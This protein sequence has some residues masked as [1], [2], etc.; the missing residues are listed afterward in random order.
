MKKRKKI[1]YSS[2]IDLYIGYMFQKSSIIILLV[3]VFVMGVCAYFI[4]NP[5]MEEVEYLASYKDYHQC[6]FSQLLLIVQIFNCIICT[7][8]VI[9]LSLNSHSFDILFTSHI[10]RKRICICKILSLMLIILI[11]AIVEVLII[12][13]VGLLRYSRLEINYTILCSLTNITISMLW[14]T[15]IVIV[16]T[17]IFPI[18]FTPMFVLLGNIIIIILCNNYDVLSDSLGGFMPILRLNTDYNL[19][20]SNNQAVAC[21]LVFLLVLLYVSIYDIKDLKN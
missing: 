16:V 20:L 19:Y 13:G 4:S 12:Y 9:I 14:Y 8:L 11:I 7:T 15:L 5:W 21:A 2:L 1:R 18:M 10:S 6:Y 17:T 3:S